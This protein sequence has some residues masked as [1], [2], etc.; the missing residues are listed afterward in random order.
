MAM[1]IVGVQ[2]DGDQHLIPVAPHPSGGFLADGECLLRRDLTLTEALDAVVAHHFSPQTEPPLHSDHLG[3]GVLRRAVDA[4]G[5]HLEV[6]LVIVLCVA[7]GGVQILVEIFRQRGLV[8]VIGVV[9]RC[10]QIPIHRPE[11]CYSHIA[12]PLS[13]QQECCCDLLQHRINSLVK[14][15]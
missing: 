7:Q 8:G 14:F 10:F 5:K 15:R 11:A 9:Q 6:G 4:A 2:V 1:H 3:V 12:S 13:R